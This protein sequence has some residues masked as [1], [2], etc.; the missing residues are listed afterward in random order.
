MPPM[1]A[2]RTLAELYP[3]ATEPGFWRAL[4][5]LTNGDIN[6]RG[7]FVLRRPISSEERTAIQERARVLGPWL[8][9]GPT[10]KVALAVTNMLL[11]F[12]ARQMSMKE[13]AAVATQYAMA[14][15]GIPLW[16]IERACMKFADNTV[17]DEDLGEGQTWNRAFG[18]SSAQLR[19]V[20]IALVR[21]FGEEST[22][23]VMTIRGTVQ[24]I[25]SDEER[26]AAAVHIDAGLADLK[27]R[28]A[29]AAL[30]Q[31]ASN[32]RRQTTLARSRR[33]NE[34][35]ILAEYEAIGLPRPTGFLTSL[36]LLLHT[37][38]T[39]QEVAGKPTL[40]APMREPIRRD[41]DARTRPEQKTKARALGGIA[42]EIIR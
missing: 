8:T 27:R 18:P 2:V 41:S 36:S 40:V 22:R 16:A 13:A 9:P 35:S 28:Q 42:Q 39:I 30:E 7:N 29:A 38:W 32:V 23:I 33:E 15:H 37:G 25:I 3:P 1:P 24:R 10:G 31:E 21:P 17:R 11:G 34:E 20:A 26:A 4:C 5:S 19:I 14:L 12:A 6:E